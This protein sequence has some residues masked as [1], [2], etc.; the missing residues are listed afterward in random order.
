MASII[1]YAT[2]DK[3]LDQT[4]DSI[5]AYTDA[6][7][8][9]DIIVCDDADIGYSRGGVLVQR[10]NKLGRA[11]AFNNAMEMAKS[12]QLIFIR[13]KTKFSEN[14]IRPL[15]EK[16]TETNII[17]PVIHSLDVLFWSTENSKWE[18]WGWR[19][20]LKLYNK[21][22]VNQFSPAISTN[23]MVIHRNRLI[24]IGLFDS[25]MKM[26]SG[27]DLELSLRNWLFGGTCMICSDS[28]V[29]VG[30]DIDVHPNTV[31]NLAR[32]VHAWLPD[33]YSYFLNAWGVQ[34]SDI[35]TGRMS[36][37]LN[38]KPQ[39]I[40]DVK[41][42]LEAYQPELFGIYN[43]KGVGTGK[44]VAVVAPGASLDYIDRSEIYKNDIIIGVDYVPLLIDC[45]YLMADTMGVV[46]AL[47][48][49]YDP[50]RFI[51]PRMVKDL[52]SGRLVPAGTAVNGCVQF[53]FEK[54]GVISSI[55]PPICDFNDMG[56]S[57]VHFALFLNPTVITLYGFDNK[58]VNGKSHTSKIAYYESGYLWSDSRGRFETAEAGLMQLGRLALSVGIPLL[59]VNHL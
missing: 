52:A 4:I 32:I 34:R 7:L 49:K 57:A 50:S 29:S 23:C 41:W 14:W 30:Y 59:R 11:V 58:F 35:D 31:N 12:D 28:T 19:W 9:D 22:P 1:I 48:S 2:D 16:L 13:S 47:L 54:F 15:L 5:I 8:L 33:Y 3:Y 25:G 21:V 39:Q 27:E 10:T 45:D 55:D 17:S 53:E 20:D 6:D 26:G 46:S 38:L 42:F 56:C 37:L 18:S 40:H 36:G 51:L 44:S 24:E 43:L